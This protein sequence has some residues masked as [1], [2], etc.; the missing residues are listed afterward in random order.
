[1]LD[2]TIKGLPDGLHARLKEH[3]ERHRRSMDSKA[4]TIL[5]RALMNR[6]PDAEELI[7]RAE[8]LNERIG[9]T[10]PDI[11]NEARQEGRARLL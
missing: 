1:M 9:K 4:I 3:A 5:E 10:F 2:L 8:A 11:V 7:R 6:R